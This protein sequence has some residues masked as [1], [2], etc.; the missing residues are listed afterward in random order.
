LPEHIF[1]VHYDV[2]LVPNFDTFFIDGK[3]TLEV[4]YPETV[5]E[6]ANKIYMVIKT[7]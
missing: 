5:A 7:N 4:T 2:E 6:F 1:P 3:M